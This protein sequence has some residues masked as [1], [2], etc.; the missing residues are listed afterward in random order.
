M[1]IDTTQIEANKNNPELAMAAIIA[2]LADL[3]TRID[4]LENPV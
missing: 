4:A 3:E 1:A 2:A